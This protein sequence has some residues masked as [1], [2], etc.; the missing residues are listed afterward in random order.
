[1]V[2]LLVGTDRGLFAIDSDE[3]RQ[4][5]RLRDV[6]HKG[7]Q[8]Y[9]TWADTRT[10][11]ATLWAGLASGFYGPHVQR[12]RD[13]G[14]TWEPIDGPRFPEGSAREMKQVWTIVPGPEPAG[15]R[16]GVAEA[17]LFSSSD[18]ASWDWNQG[19]ESH[20]SREEWMPGAG[21]LCVHTIVQDPGSADRIFIGMSAVGVFRTDDGGR[22]WAIKNK[23][24]AAADEEE[25]VK[26]TEVMCCV[27]RL[28]QDPTDTSRLYQQN[29]TGVYRSTTAG[30][31]WERIEDG[32]PSNFGF[33]MVMH[34]KK[35]RTLFI[36]PLDGDEGRV[37]PGGR[38]GV[39]RTDDA[40]DHWVRT[41]RG[42]EDPCYTGVLRGA[43]TADGE[44]EPGVYFGTTGGDVYATLDEGESWQRLPGR[45]PRVLSVT[46]LSR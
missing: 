40:G 11:P 4:V 5:W 8:V 38:P 36:V 46:A 10:Q 37:F 22:T 7:W 2:T 34:P 17:A 18:G 6:A 25:K 21:G 1:M 24:I 9:S 42:L 16:A 14:E 19:L 45:L 41:H 13:G 20:P 3:R 32:L 39:F 31:S 12:S 35:P 33:P 29:H 30:D 15:L 23:G 27:H 26:Y 43:M 44:D 28:V